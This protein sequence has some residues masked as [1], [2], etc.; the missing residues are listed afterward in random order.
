MSHLGSPTRVVVEFKCKTCR[1]PC[2]I[3]ESCLTNYE[4]DGQPLEVMRP[5]HGI[6]T[7][8]ITC[9]RVYQAS[10]KLR[11]LVVQNPHLLTD[12]MGGVSEVP[13]WEDPKDV[14]KV[15]TPKE[16][17]G[18]GRDD[19][20]RRG[21]LEKM[22]ESFVNSA[23]KGMTEEEVYGYSDEASMHRRMS[24]TSTQVGEEEPGKKEVADEDDAKLI[25]P[26]EE[27]E[28]TDKPN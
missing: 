27:M 4:C 1:N 20:E 7:R 23:G 3:D 18:D 15:N 22:I 8:C 24:Q 28:A 5:V 13:S 21:F 10:Y 17:L 16:S 19:D 26:D 2:W 12:G 14:A 25:S 6:P 11:D 9:V